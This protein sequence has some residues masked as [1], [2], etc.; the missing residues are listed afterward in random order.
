MALGLACAWL[1][2]GELQAYEGHGTGVRL[3][4]VRRTSGLRGTWDWR[5]PG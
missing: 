3:A 1:R 2:F 4:E 5:A